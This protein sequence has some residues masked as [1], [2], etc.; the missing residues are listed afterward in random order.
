MATNDVDIL[1]LQ[2]FLKW[3]NIQQ[4]GGALREA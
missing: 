3:A 1:D 4:A 2:Q